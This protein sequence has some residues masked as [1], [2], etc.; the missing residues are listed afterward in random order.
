LRLQDNSLLTVISSS[1]TPTLIDDY[2]ERWGIETLFGILKTRGFN[3]EDT[4]I[5][6]SERLSRLFAL[7]TIGLCWVYRYCF[8][9]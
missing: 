7:L 2:A 4:H 9:Y 5:I 1:Y 3:L 8:D 6:D